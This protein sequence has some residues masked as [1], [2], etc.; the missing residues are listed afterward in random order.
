MSLFGFLDHPE[1]V[2]DEFKQFVQENGVPRLNFEDFEVIQFLCSGSFGSCY[3]ARR[4]SDGEV[5]ALKF[6]GYSECNPLDD[7]RGIEREI[8]T[9]WSFNDFESTAKCLGYIVD[10]Y[11][12][13]VKDVQ[14]LPVDK[15]M[16]FKSYPHHTGKR[17]KCKTVVKISE[18][19]RA[20]VLDYILTMPMINDKEISRIFKNF[21]EGLASI[22]SANYI[23]R[24]L[25]PENIMLNENGVLRLIDFG[26]ARKIP[27]GATEVVDR[28][29][30]GSRFYRA[31]ET[32]TGYRT[33]K[34][35]D[36]WTVGT[37]LYVLLFGCHAF[38]TDYATTSGRYS[39]PSKSN[40]SAKAVDLLSKLLQ[41]SPVKRLTCEEVLRHP[42]I[43]RAGELEEFTQEVEQF[44]EEY[45][46]NI[47]Y[48]SY[49]SKLKRIL[50][51]KIAESINRKRILTFAYKEKIGRDIDLTVDQ[52]HTLREDF[53]RVNMEII[54]QLSAESQDDT[55][56]HVT[57][58]AGVLNFMSGFLGT[59]KSPRV[60]VVAGGRSSALPYDTFCEVM[61]RNHL[62]PFATTEM[63]NVFDI[64]A[65]GK[66]DY[67]ELM[68]NLASLRADNK[69][70]HLEEEA[71]MYFDIFDMDGNGTIQREEFVG[72]VHHILGSSTADIDTANFDQLFAS[73]NTTDGSPGLDREQ[74]KNFYKTLISGNN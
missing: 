44:G 33:S 15:D 12:G 70:E 25:K 4:R 30:R 73:I 17:Y 72:F 64:D 22:H 74:F 26:M 35:S 41:V 56:I 46:K 61:I 7:L 9:D 55:P 36:M 3:K 66:V 11:D 50:R 71:N 42:W 8:E 54:Q 51:E 19:L 1:K 21:V 39:I 10:S 58:V 13:Y 60:R 14:R 40:R 63:F 16:G 29:G 48:W 45:I 47:K 49:N 18:C 38:D 57:A 53:F 23:H 65:S 52:F 6:F 68:V 62:Q 31:P 27:D 24:D 32:V 5:V 43:T 20:E 59:P 2:S 34:A 69:S 37:I 67:F 28:S